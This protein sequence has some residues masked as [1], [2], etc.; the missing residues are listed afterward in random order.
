MKT[1]ICSIAKNE[2]N[3]LLEWVTYHINLGFSHIYIYDNN[4]EDG[5]QIEDVLEEHL[6]NN[7]FIIDCRGKKRHQATAYTEFY[8]LFGDQYHWVA[9]ID[10]DEFITFTNKSKL[11]YI[12]DYLKTIKG[13]DIIHLN[14]MSYGDNEIVEYDSNNVLER[15]TKPLPFD[16]CI[17]YNFPENNHVK[18]IIKGRLNLD[19]VQITPHSPS[20]NFSI[21]DEMGIKRSENS[22]FK[23]FSYE[24]AYIRH[25]TT[26]TIYEWL[27]KIARGRATVNSKSDLYSIDRFF[28]YNEK[29]IEKQNVIKYFLLFKS[30]MKNQSKLELNILNREL[31]T[32]KEENI[33]LDMRL[34]KVTKSK[35]YRIGKLLLKPLS[36]LK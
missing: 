36:Y 12:E 34:S 4:D 32:L 20:G 15:F 22:Y 3:Y 21:C 31:D 28:K 6:G 23:P 17:Q 24:V 14:W 30:V 35:A 26:K 10:I 29:T 1:A 16:K 25:F 8:Q 2:N 7:V 27:K 18:S 33:K 19:G 9:Y 11:L 5:E 13:F